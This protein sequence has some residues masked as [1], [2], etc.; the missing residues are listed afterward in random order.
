MKTEIQN[1]L[2][3]L[4]LKQSIP[5]CYGCYQDAP[6]GQCKY[7]GSD[8]L[9]RHLHGIGCEYGTEWI[10]QHILETELT[11]VDTEEVFEESIRQCYPEETK[12]GWMT[13]DTVTLMKSQDPISW[14]IA[15]DEW[16]SSEEDDGNIISFDNGSTYYSLE[17]LKLLVNE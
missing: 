9:M 17:K 4:A 12:V 6:T 1:K 8:D 16:A 2:H 10:V 5:F 13:F 15:C 11:P 7:C 3:Q 14:K